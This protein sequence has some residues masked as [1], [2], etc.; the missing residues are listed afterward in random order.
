[1]DK[2][3]KEVWTKTEKGEKIERNGY[4]L[5]Y[6]KKHKPSKTGFA[7]NYD[8]QRKGLAKKNWS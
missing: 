5:V 7:G 3:K 4:T 6:T 2:I 8:R 1:M